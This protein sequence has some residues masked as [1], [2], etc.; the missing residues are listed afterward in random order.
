MKDC[1]YTGI[2]FHCM[3]VRACALAGEGAILDRSIFSDYVFASVGHSQ[4]FISKEGMQMKIHA[5]LFA[6]S[7]HMKE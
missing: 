6:S 5:S 3:C 7:L 1:L 4:G 2:A